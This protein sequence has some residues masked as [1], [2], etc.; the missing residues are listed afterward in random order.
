MKIL[1]PLDGSKFAEEILEPAAQFAERCHA[2]VRLMEVVRGSTSTPW[3]RPPPPT[4]PITWALAWR[5][6]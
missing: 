1:I 4:N 5:W 3:I 2:E 6:G